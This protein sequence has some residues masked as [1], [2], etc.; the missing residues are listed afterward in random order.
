MI[1][2][3]KLYSGVQYTVYIVVKYAG[4]TV[5]DTVDITVQVCKVN[6]VVQCTGYTIQYTVDTIQISVHC[7]VK[8]PQ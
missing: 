1:Q 2:W 8:F 6:S 3:T 7:S 5:H 4:Y